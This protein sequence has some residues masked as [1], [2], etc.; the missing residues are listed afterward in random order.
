LGQSLLEFGGLVLKE[1]TLALQE[2]LEHP[3]AVAVAVIAPRK[4]VF[5]RTRVAHDCAASSA[6]DDEGGFSLRELGVIL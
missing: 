1:L 6:G 2:L 3:L 4:L 5:G